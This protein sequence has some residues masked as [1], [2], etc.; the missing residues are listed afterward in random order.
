MLTAWP[1]ASA[2]STCAEQPFIGRAGCQFIFCLVRA[3]ARHVSAGDVSV[4]CCVQCAVSQSLQQFRV[5][6]KHDN[7]GTVYTLRPRLAVSESD[8]RRA[9]KTRGGLSSARLA[10][11]L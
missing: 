8:A 11:R 3:R 4:L 6:R 10:S 9:Q 7:Y 2:A 5:E 1:T